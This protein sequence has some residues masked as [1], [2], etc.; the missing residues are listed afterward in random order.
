MKVEVVY[1]TTERQELIQLDVPEGT[2]LLQAVKLSAICEIFPEIDLSVSDM[3]VWGGVDSPDRVL[4]EWDRVEIYRPL[5][6]DPREARR[7]RA[8]EQ[9]IKKKRL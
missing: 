4:K 8:T 5:V 7:Q 6:M 2:T 3:G 1:G 9:P